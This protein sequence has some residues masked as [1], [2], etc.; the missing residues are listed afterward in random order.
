MRICSKNAVKR[1]FRGVKGGISTTNGNMSNL[2]LFFEFH[3][4]ASGKRNGGAGLIVQLQNI[5]VLGPSFNLAHLLQIDK[6]GTETDYTIFMTQKIPD[7]PKMQ[8][9]R[10][11]QQ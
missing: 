4:L 11:I 3:I 1:A 7:E 2:E 5:T 6:V 10:D 8:F 9:I